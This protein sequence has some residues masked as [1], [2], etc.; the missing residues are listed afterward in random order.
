L[1]GCEV[2]AERIGFEFPRLR[3]GGVHARLLE[4][5]AASFEL[6]AL[7]LDALAKA[8]RR[9][10][11]EHGHAAQQ[12]ALLAARRGIDDRLSLRALLAHPETAAGRSQCRLALAEQIGL[13]PLR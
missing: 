8:P 4:P 11:G 2:G 10:E 3:A 7:G 6:G 13:E 12:R 5:P 9:I 1:L